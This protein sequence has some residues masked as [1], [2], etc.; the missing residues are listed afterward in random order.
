MM[1]VREMLGAMERRQGRGRAE[2]RTV[3]LAG[4]KLAWV[5]LPE[6]EGASPRQRERQER[7]GWRLLRRAGVSQ[8]VLPGDWDGEVPAGFARVETLP[9]YR[10]Q[11]DLLALGALARQGIP[12][13]RACVGLSA[14]RLSSELQRAALLLCPRV[15]RLA[16]DVPGGGAEY[17]Q[18]LHRRYGLP[19]E[20]AG[21]ADAAVHFG[22]CPAW[23]RSG[24]VCLGEETFRLGGLR[25][26]TPGL[27]LPEGYAEGL[28]AALWQRG[29]LRRDDLR[30]EWDGGGAWRRLKVNP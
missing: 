14:P 26:C 18:W 1:G 16:I 2:L 3:E 8:V 24:D 12:P 9:F 13:E 29:L 21:H 25:L 23:A 19:V 15:R 28:R 17:A 30:V 10:A 11:A 22:P 5:T 4:M 7:R 6:P 20:P 27:A